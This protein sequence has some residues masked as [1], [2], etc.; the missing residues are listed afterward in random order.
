MALLEKLNLF[1]NDNIIKKRYKSNAS[2]LPLENEPLGY[3]QN[4]MNIDCPFY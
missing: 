1:T 2:H 3:P 4:C